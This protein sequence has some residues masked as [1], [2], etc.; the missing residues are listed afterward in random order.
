MRRIVWPLAAGYSTLE[1][2]K[3]IGISRSSVE[4]LVDELRDELENGCA[5]NGL[6]TSALAP[7]DTGR[8]QRAVRGRE[9][10]ASG[11][12]RRT[13]RDGLAWLPHNQLF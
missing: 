9:I 8:H 1:V 5:A 10:P 11:S 6:L 4:R 13:G 3:S 7:A 12:L 2:A